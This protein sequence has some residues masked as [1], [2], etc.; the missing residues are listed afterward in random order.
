MREQVAVLLKRAGA[1][2]AVMQL[3]RYVPVPTLSII[4]YHHVQ[5][6]DPTYPYDPEVA[7]AT[8]SQF[9]RQ[10]ETL[11]RYCTPIGVDELMRAIE[12]EPLPKNPVMVTFDDGYRSCHDVA[13]PIL[14]A[15]GVRATF[16]VST[17]FVSDRRLYWWERIALMLAHGKRRIA[18]ITY[19]TT[20]E[21]DRKHPRM[22]HRLAAL[23]KDTPS[24]DV[25]RFLEELA[26]AFAV[27][28][29]REAET[30]YA[31]GLIMTWDHVRALA[32]AG[33]D[34]ESHGRRHRVLQ[35]LDRTEL[36][37]E[38]AGSRADL[39]SQLGRP[40]RAVAYPVGRRI[41][42]DSKIRNAIASA[43]Y[44]IGLTNASGVN[45]LWPLTMR[46]VWPVAPV[47]PFDVRRLSTDRQMSDA[48]FLTQVAV[49][50]FAYVARV[51]QSP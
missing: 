16:F 22:Q 28:W 32:R 42:P 21:L 45:R 2:D 41:S 13:L 36:E 15:V 14:R 7:D 24:L 9:R 1:L 44:R 8:P 51:N 17:G 29:N 4:T 50:Q 34:V 40:V 3:R 10:M 38:L 39:E 6:H 49:P 12:G 19:P 47:D 11:A 43:G 5:E 18:T 31:D 33:M 37:D 20:L 35:T 46:A 25:E 30:T 26:R 48:M 27:D 23:V